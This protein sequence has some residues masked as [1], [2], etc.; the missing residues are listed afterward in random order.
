VGKYE[1]DLDTEGVAYDVYQMDLADNDR[2]ILE[3][4]TDGFVK[5]ICAK[6]TDKILGGTIVAEN[7]GDMIGE[8]GVALQN[9]V[10]L[11]G[12]GATIHPYPTQ[13]DAIRRVSS[14]SS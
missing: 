6:G 2:A 13:A 5:V 7:A 3:G 12:I 10:G 9:G 1:R 11:S 8:I 4:S 14:T